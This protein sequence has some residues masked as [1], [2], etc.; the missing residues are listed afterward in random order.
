MP[1]AELSGVTHGTKKEKIKQIIIPGRLILSGIIWCSRSIKVITIRAAKNIKVKN[2]EKDKPKKKRSKRN[3]KDESESKLTVY[4][5][6]LMRVGTFFVML[7][8]M[9]IA[10]LYVIFAFFG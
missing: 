5:K 3:Q 9:F 10:Y 6:N 4:L 8:A 2:K 7:Q 1:I